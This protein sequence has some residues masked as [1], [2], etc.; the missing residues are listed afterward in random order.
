MEIQSSAPSE[1]PSELLLDYNAAK[2]KWRPSRPQMFKVSPQLRM[3]QGQQSGPSVYDPILVSLGPYHHGEHVLSQAQE[4]KYHSLHWLTEGNDQNIGYLFNKIFSR[5]DE[6]RG[7]YAEDSI[8]NKYDDNALAKMM[9]LDACFIIHFMHI[10]DSMQIANDWCGSLGMAA[11]VPFTVRDIMVL[12][13]Q[14]PFLVLKLLLDEKENGG[15]LLQKFLSWILWVPK[16]L[17]IIPREF[18]SPPLHI[19]EACRRLLTEKYTPKGTNQTH[20]YPTTIS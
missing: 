1:L 14:I 20:K 11:A 5:I 18:E 4:F 9:L 15:E 13:N 7:C 10:R 17:A 8:V 16:E 3:K 6:I 2:N 19:L 12:E